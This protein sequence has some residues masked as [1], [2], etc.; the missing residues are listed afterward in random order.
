[1]AGPL[2][3]EAAE[4]MAAWLQATTERAARHHNLRHPCTSPRRWAARQALLTL[5]AAPATC[6]QL[7][8][9]GGAPAYITESNQQQSHSWRW[10][11]ACRALR[12]PAL[13]IKP[14]TTN[15]C[16]IGYYAS[17]HRCLRLKPAS[18]AFL[19]RRAPLTVPPTPE[20]LAACSGDI[21]AFRQHQIMLG[22]AGGGGVMGGVGA[23]GEACAPLRQLLAAGCA[24]TYPAAISDERPQTAGLSSTGPSHHCACLLS[25][26]RRPHAPAARQQHQR[27]GAPSSGRP[28][29][30]APRVW[31]RAGRPGARGW[32]AGAPGVRAAGRRLARLG[33]R[34]REQQRVAGQGGRG[35]RRCRGRGRRRADPRP[36]PQQRLVAKA[37]QGVTR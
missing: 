20:W 25:A 34:P 23:A 4:R 5:A 36:P 17:A 22:P 15:C 33:H 31:R 11:A 1:M 32:A 16:S 37:V 24:C 19:A 2:E 27:R 30:R 12:L 9:G 8:A 18:H 7:V 29:A 35:W 13:P 28:A 10:G 26:R 14:V 3:Q 6:Q 21:S